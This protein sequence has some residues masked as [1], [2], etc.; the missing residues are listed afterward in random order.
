M[1]K[2][3][4][5]PPLLLRVWMPLNRVEDNSFASKQIELEMWHSS[6]YVGALL[7][8]NFQNY[9]KEKY[10]LVCHDSDV[11]RRWSQCSFVFSLNLVHNVRVHQW[12]I[13]NRITVVTVEGNFCGKVV[14]FHTYNTGIKGSKKTIYNRRYKV[15]GGYPYNHA[16]RLMH[17]LTH[18]VSISNWLFMDDFV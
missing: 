1:L 17:V 9:A 13:C 7:N 3:I 5:W 16:L 11:Y 6:V 12:S 2:Q 8:F 15:H 18:S 4:Q 14:L 10:L